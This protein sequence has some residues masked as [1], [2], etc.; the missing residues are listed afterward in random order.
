MRFVV[1]ESI[2]TK[3]LQE[4]LVKPKFNYKPASIFKHNPS[5]L[6][7]DVRVGVR[8]NFEIIISQV[9]LGPPFRL[10]S[11]SISELRSRG[12]LSYFGSFSEEDLSRTVQVLT[13]ISLQK[14]GMFCSVI[15]VGLFQSF[16]YWIRSWRLFIYV[17][18]RMFTGKEIENVYLV[19][20]P[21]T[22]S[23]TGENI[24]NPVHR[25][26]EGVLGIE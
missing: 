10:T 26:L 16:R 3:S 1:R 6:F 13:V 8:K 7:F 17:R 5:R 25:L 2:F 21:S 12:A 4:V 19:A 9:S 15:V 11:R 14:I 24:A 20:I 23:R 18:F 22:V